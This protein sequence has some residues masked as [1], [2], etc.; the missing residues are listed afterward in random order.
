[1]GPTDAASPMMAPAVIDHTEEVQAAV[2]AL[3][4]QSGGFLQDGRA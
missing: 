2:K 4:N 3:Q 1:M